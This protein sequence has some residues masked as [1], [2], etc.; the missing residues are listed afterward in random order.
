M[1]PLVIFVISLVPGL[2][3][4]W[5]F[6]R[7][8]REREPPS[9]ILWTFFAG[10]LAVVP[11]ALLEF[12]FRDILANPP[13]LAT[14]LAVAFLV[15]GL[16]EEGAKILAVYLAAFRNREFNQVVDG[17]IYAVSASLGFAA[18]ENLLYTTTFGLSVAPARAVVTSL[19]HASFGG[20]AGLYL[21]LA[22][23]RPGHGA[24]TVLRGLVI[25]AGL[26]GL[27][28]FLIMARLVHP[29]FAIALVYFS[30]RFVSRKIRDLDEEALVRSE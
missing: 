17:I 14:R 2:L 4:V 29:I 8:D 24:G 20:I 15:I 5:F 11:A 26:H 3:W 13:N 22:K 27:Y 28:D 6:Y 21:G 10:M 1:N 16:A 12:P 9:L 30:Y 19:A 23:L 25:A 18:L 7:Q